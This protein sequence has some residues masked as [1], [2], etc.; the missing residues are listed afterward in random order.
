MGKSKIQKLSSITD[1]SIIKNMGKFKLDS[2]KATYGARKVIWD[3]GDGTSVRCSINELIHKMNEIRPNFENK[4]KGEKFNNALKKLK[5]LDSDTN[6]EMKAKHAN[7]FQK[8]MRFFRQA[9]GKKLPK[10][11]KKREDAFEKLPVKVKKEKKSSS[12]NQKESTQSSKDV[13]K[14]DSQKSQKT[15]SKNESA[16]E[17]ILLGSKDKDQDSLGGGF[18][19]KIEG[20]SEVFLEEEVPPIIKNKSAE[21][22]KKI[23]LKNQGN[24]GGNSPLAQNIPTEKPEIKDPLLEV[25]GSKREAFKEIFGINSGNQCVFKGINSNENGG[26][27][28]FQILPQGLKGYTV[29]VFTDSNEKM[30]YSV[31]MENFAGGSDEI[32]DAKEY[33]EVIGACFN[34]QIENIQ[35]I[36]DGNINNLESKASLTF[37]LDLEHIDKD[38]EMPK[39]LAEQLK[40]TYFTVCAL[41][42][43]DK[44]YLDAVNL[45]FEKTEP[46]KVVGDI[47]SRIRLELQG[48]EKQLLSAD[49]YVAAKLFNIALSQ[50]F[51]SKEGEEFLKKEKLNYL[52]QMENNAAFFEKYGFHLQERKPKNFCNFQTEIFKNWVN[53]DKIDNFSEVKFFCRPAMESKELFQHLENEV[54]QNWGKAET[55]SQF[56]ASFRVIFLGSPSENMPLRIQQLL[57]ASNNQGY[58]P[59]DFLVEFYKHNYHLLRG[60]YF[61]EHIKALLEEALASDS[62]EKK[63]RSFGLLGHILD[64]EQQKEFAKSYQDYL[65]TLT[66]SEYRALEKKHEDSFKIINEFNPDV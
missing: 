45:L 16:E 17:E 14:K 6:K 49:N 57:D 43:K 66:V 18:P 42:D 37:N 11:F 1:S 38:P 53:N 46:E 58:D 44:V 32:N 7:I 34:G 20:G 56:M 60:D 2:N 30:T 24:L 8:I 54:T 59:F 40:A 35:Y 62:K 48:E 39:F 31:I 29:N 41:N 22:E 27:K 21:P 25:P 52:G 55:L 64:Q 10:E 19:P 63:E 28:T 5:D 3:K 36:K 12:K 65:N 26:Y 9:L 61:Q 47:L 15:S 4:K 13:S 51:G 23:P 33:L 50:W